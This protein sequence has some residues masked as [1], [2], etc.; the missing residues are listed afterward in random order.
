MQVKMGQTELHDQEKQNQ[1]H[2]NKESSILG[3]IP[4]GAADMRA[5]DGFLSSSKILN[6]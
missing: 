5:H 4:C 2:K 1:W 3:S 6:R